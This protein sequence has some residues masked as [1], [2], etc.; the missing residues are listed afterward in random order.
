MEEAVPA[1][2]DELSRLFNAYKNTGNKELK[3]L[4]EMVD[5]EKVRTRAQLAADQEASY[6]TTGDELRR[7][8]HDPEE[9]KRAII[10]S[11]IIRRRY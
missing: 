7:I 6:G 1:H 2:D 4:D 11:E 3:T 10:L 8:L 5:I 9:A